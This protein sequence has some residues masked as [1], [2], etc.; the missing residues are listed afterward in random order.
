MRHDAM[1]PVSA[2]WAR[3][4]TSQKDLGEG[5]LV[6]KRIIIPGCLELMAL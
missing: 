4:A 5:L 6:S 2:A 1:M 3:D